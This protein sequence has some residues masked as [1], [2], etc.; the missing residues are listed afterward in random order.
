MKNYTSSIPEHFKINLNQNLWGI[1]A[2]FLALGAAE[3]YNLKAL[4]WFAVI[5]SGIMSISIAVTTTAYTIRYLGRRIQL[6]R[7]IVTIALMILLIMACMG[8]TF[9]YETVSNNAQT[10]TTYLD[11]KLGMTMAEVEYVKGPPA[12]VTQNPEDIKND[13]FKDFKPAIYTKDLQ[14]DQNIE[15]FREWSYELDQQGTRMDVSFDEKTKTLNSISCY[16]Q[17]SGN[18]AV[19]LGIQDGTREDEVLKKL[20]NPS[21]ENMSGTTKM[22]AYDRLGVWFYLS[23]MKVYMLGVEK[24]VDTRK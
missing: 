2:S 16:S 5:L 15:H 10:Q 18:C 9:F 19:V 20:G 8:G 11:L 1:A 7:R 3:H 6:S 12:S 23:R 14:G 17:G 21:S 22:I 13:P 24:H 4:F